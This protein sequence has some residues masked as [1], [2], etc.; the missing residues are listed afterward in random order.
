MRH[1]FRLGPVGGTVEPTA[2]Y[3]RCVLVYYVPPEAGVHRT[4]FIGLLGSAPPLPPSPH[5]LT[6]PLPD[7][8]WLEGHPSRF[9][10]AAGVEASWQTINGQLCLTNAKS[11]DRLGQRGPLGVCA[12]CRQQ[13]D[14][15]S[16]CARCRRILYCSRA[17]QVAHWRVH[18]QDCNAASS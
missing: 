5:L 3:G 7:V 6:A 4:Q 18:R 8:E 15:L 16:R 12:Q 13:P 9:T 2:Y 17:C 14:T 10:L 11:L 1:C